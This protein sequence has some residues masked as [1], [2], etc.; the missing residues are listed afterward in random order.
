MKCINSDIKGAV[1][2]PKDRYGH[3]LHVGDTVRVCGDTG[4]IERIVISVM[5]PLDDG[6]YDDPWSIRVVDSL[7][8]DDCEWSCWTRGSRI[9]LA[10]DE[11]DS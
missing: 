7:V 10:C 1:F 4:I 3:T 11:V 5:R 6:R 9:E 2:L 8:F